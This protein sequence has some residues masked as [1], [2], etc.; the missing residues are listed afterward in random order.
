MKYIIFQDFG[1]KPVPFIFPNRVEHVDMREQM[2]YSK[3]LSCGEVHLV[4]GAFVCSGGDAELGAQAAPDD[5]EIIAE[6]FRADIIK[7]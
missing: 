1:G 5:A 6:P 3:V 4:D 7:A 2:P